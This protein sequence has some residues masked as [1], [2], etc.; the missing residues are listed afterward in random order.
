M[1]CGE[2]ERRAPFARHGNQSAISGIAGTGFDTSRARHRNPTHD[3][4]HAAG[5]ALLETMRRPGIGGVLQSV[6]DVYRKQGPEGRV[7]AVAQTACEIEQR[8][9]VGAAAVGDDQAATYIL[10][11]ALSRRRG[12][13]GTPSATSTPRQRNSPV[14]EGKEPRVFHGAL[15]RAQQHAI[16]RTLRKAHR[17]WLRL[18]WGLP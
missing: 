7:A 2:H 4:F 11:P 14:R 13:G 12:R 6:M 3:T 5:G 8:G 10:T 15:Q 17:D 1:V 9:G 16:F 18:R